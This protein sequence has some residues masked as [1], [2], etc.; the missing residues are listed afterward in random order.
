MSGDGG[1][2]GACFAGNGRD[3][4][5]ARLHQ[6]QERCKYMVESAAKGGSHTRVLSQDLPAEGALLVW[7]AFRNP[8]GLPPLAAHAPFFRRQAFEAKHLCP[9]LAA[10]PSKL[11]NLGTFRLA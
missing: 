9:R 7:G 11:G 8:N 1:E 6:Q 5:C 3:L 2:D 10:G 4:D